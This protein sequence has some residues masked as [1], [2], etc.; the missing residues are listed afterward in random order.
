MLQ[1]TDWIRVADTKAAAILAG[2]GVLGG[3]LVRAFP[4]VA[5]WW[6]QPWHCGFLLASLALV[7]TSGLLAL[8]VFAPRLRSGGRRSLIYFD[9]IAAKYSR[10]A[11]FK[12]AYL[13]M[14]DR[15]GQLREA[16]AEQLWATSRI[17]REKFRRVTVSVWLLAGALITAIAGGLLTGL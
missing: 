11:D 6:S 1:T 2:G 7:T 5:Q 12:T 3:V 17:A 10:M 4:V 15:E 13:A 9:H 16:L 8:T 14:L